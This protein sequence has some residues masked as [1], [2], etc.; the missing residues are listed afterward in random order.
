MSLQIKLI[1]YVTEIQTCF[2]CWYPDAGFVDNGDTSVVGKKHS[3]WD[4][5]LTIKAAATYIIFSEKQTKL[6]SSLL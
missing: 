3:Y 5:N 4:S 6:A 1:N 2:Y